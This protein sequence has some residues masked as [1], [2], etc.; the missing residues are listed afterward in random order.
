[1]VDLIPITDRINRIIQKP[2]NKNILEGHQTS[3]VMSAESLVIMQ[4][5][6]APNDHSNNCIRKRSPCKIHYLRMKFAP[7]TRTIELYDAI[8]RIRIQLECIIDSGSAVSLITFGN[9]KDCT[10][11]PLTTKLEL[12]GAF[13]GTDVEMIG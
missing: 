12:S 7:L 5:T 6:V 13:G 10:I 8:K 3:L 4:R 1:M 11:S 2:D 9:V